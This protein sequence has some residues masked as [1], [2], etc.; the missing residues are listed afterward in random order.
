MTPYSLLSLCLLLASLSDFSTAFVVA[1]RALA[2][3]RI[4]CFSEEPEA[5]EKIEPKPE[6]KCPDCDLCDGSG[7]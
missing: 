6:V 3:P 4:V 1:P 5:A 7:R 2:T